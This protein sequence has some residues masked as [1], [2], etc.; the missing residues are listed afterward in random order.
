[1]RALCCIWL[2]CCV[3]R[4]TC[5]RVVCS[6]SARFLLRAMAA[7]DDVNQTRPNKMLIN[8]FLIFIYEIVRHTTMLYMV[9]QPHD[10]PGQN[11]NI[12]LAHNS[13]A[14]VHFGLTM[15]NLLLARH[16][17]VECVYALYRIQIHATTSP[18]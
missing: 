11:V 18:V 10:E 3:S 5:N 9:Q 8:K 12:W 7:C 13:A 4:C 14:H 17:L 2:V 1:M 16:M 15:K 6:R